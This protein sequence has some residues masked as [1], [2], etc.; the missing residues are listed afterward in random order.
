[1]SNDIQDQS[2]VI[3]IIFG[4]WRS[5]ILHAGVKLN[6]FE[7]IGE[8]KS[9][10]ELAAKVDADPNL[11][12]RLLRALASLGFLTE[13]SEHRFSMSSMGE[14]LRSDHPHSLRAMILLEEGPVHY[15][16]WK[17]LPELIREGAQ[18]GF[19]REVG[20]PW[21]E[22]LQEDS[23]YAGIFQD[24]M[25]SYSSTEASAVCDALRQ[26]EFPLDDVHYCDVGGG[27]GYLLAQILKSNT[28]ATGVVF[29]LPEVATQTMRHMTRGADL[30]DR[31]RHVGGNM[32]ESVPDGANIYLMKHIIHDWN[33]AEC[34]QILKSIRRAARDNCK[35]IICEMLIPRHDLSHFSK[36]FD[37]H[38]L[39][40]SS[41]RQRTV[42]E[43]SEMLE[44]SGWEF[45]LEAPVS[46]TPLSLI[47]ATPAPH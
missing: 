4:R 14:F 47:V 25:S 42:T 26:L 24:A 7:S 36:I 15:A 32:F 2:K 33:D 3:D 22:Y 10:A 39:C 17:H 40:A 34:E 46:N 1:M 43:I 19:S 37:I 12:Y 29:D 18:D 23:T 35:L 16:A 13:S 41:G 5:Q 28:H 9:A 27:D 8:S 6:V 38:M 31:V 30:Q 11:L 45:S 20:K 44:N 21:V